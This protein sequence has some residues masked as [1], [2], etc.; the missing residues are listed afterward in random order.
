VRASLAAQKQGLGTLPPSY[1]RP[2]GGNVEAITETS[3]ATVK[4][5]CMPTRTMPISTADSRRLRIPSGH[6][7]KSVRI[8]SVRVVASHSYDVSRA[9]TDETTVMGIDYRGRGQPWCARAAVF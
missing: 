1:G 4:T 8:G 6:V 3:L 2:Q 9:L 5:A 7:R